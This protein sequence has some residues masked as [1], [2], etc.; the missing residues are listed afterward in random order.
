[1]TPLPVLGSHELARTGG[2][3]PCRADRRGRGSRSARRA[4][5]SRRAGTIERRTASQPSWRAA[6]GKE[7]PQVSDDPVHFPQKTARRS[8]RGALLPLDRFNAFSDG[9]FA[10][11]I[12]LLVLEIAIPHAGVRV[13]PALREQWPEFLG[14]YISFAFI[15]GIWIAHSGVTKFMKQRGR[16]VVLAEPA[17]AALRRPAALQHGAHG[18]APERGRPQ[19]RGAVLRRQP[20]ARLARAQPAHPLPRA[21]TVAARRRDRRRHAAAHHPAALDRLSG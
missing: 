1:M 12:T 8:A 9:V 14:Y 21:G 2:H 13:L 6:A 10:I 15:G 16:G 11:A 18:H 3:M 7:R 4:A 19:A 5:S 17:A 20:A